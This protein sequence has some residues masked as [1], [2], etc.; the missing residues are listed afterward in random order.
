L[1]T[2]SKAFER[3]KSIALWPWSAPIKKCHKDHKKYDSGA[4]AVIYACELI[5]AYPLES[6]I[7]ERQ[8]FK[9]FKLC[10]ICFVERK[11]NSKLR[12]VCF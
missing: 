9:S 3:V 5:I 11:R 2:Q 8:Y 6:I 12:N 10:C 1:T 7:K 4:N